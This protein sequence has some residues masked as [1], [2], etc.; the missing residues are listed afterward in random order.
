[1][2]GAR[3]LRELALH[4]AD[5]PEVFAMH[6]TEQLRNR[7]PVEVAA[8]GIALLGGE[9]AIANRARHHD[10][11]IAREFSVS[12]HS[13]DGKMEMLWKDV[14]RYRDDP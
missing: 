6:Q 10:V 5:G 7:E 14:R 3:D 8:A 13:G 4:G 11:S 12:N 9:A 1:M 2:D